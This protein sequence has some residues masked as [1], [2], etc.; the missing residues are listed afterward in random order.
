MFRSLYTRLGIIA[1]L[2]T[3]ALLV[4]LPRIP[5]DINNNVLKLDSAVG[6]YYFTL[7]GKTFDLRD[8][9]KGLDLKGGIRIVLKADMSK[10]ASADQ[11]NALESAKEV[12]SRRVNLLGVTESNVTTQ[13]TQT[14][15]RI[16]VE[17]PGVD[18]VTDAVN[19]IGQTAQLT[20]KELKPGL[21]YTQ[22]KFFT[23]YSDPTSWQ[24]TGI[25]GAD[26]K[27]A[28]VVVNQNGDIQTS[29]KPEIQLQFTNEG[30]Q[31]FSDVAKR[32]INKPIALFLDQGSYPISAPIVN[33]DLAQGLTSDPV[34]SGNFDFNSAKDLSIQIRAGALPVPVSVLQQETIGATLGNTSVERSFFA[35]AVGLLLVLIFL[36]FKYGKLGGLAGAALMIYALLVLAIFKIIPVT[37]TLPGIAGF[38]LSIGMATDANILVF[39]R[40]K[41]EIMWGK[42]KNLA[43]HLGFDRAWNSIRDSN[44]SSLITSLILFQFG[45]GPI[46]GFAL[47]LAIG[48]VV[49]L[50]TSIFVVRTFIELRQQ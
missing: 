5:I 1:A 35:G 11:A 23:Y 47:T 38:V 14:D 20:F 37:L 17:I 25:T 48:I 8:F 4:V 29:G 36:I 21:E 18:N 43:I 28:T 39:E 49:S 30:R 40:T 32:N 16:I 50:F 12:I 6:G 15:S 34:I 9:K 33:P 27:G 19:L 3:I 42:P 41:E 31:K 46:R 44:I 10:I 2:T 13:R 22:D 7:F 24:D 45:T 26:M